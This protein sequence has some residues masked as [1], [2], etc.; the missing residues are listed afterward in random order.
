M[1]TTRLAT[2]SQRAREWKTLWGRLGWVG[3]DPTP[4][5][6]GE[7]GLP[8]L[9]MHPSSPWTGSGKQGARVT[10]FSCKFSN[11]HISTWWNVSNRFI[12]LFPPFQAAS[13]WGIFPSTCYLMNQ[14]TL[15]VGP[16]SII[17]LG[18]TQC[19]FSNSSILLHLWAVICPWLTTFIN[20]LTDVKY[21]LS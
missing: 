3:L 9:R 12:S 15:R 4:L 8:L 13:P 16:G 2:F 6:C 17:H 10:V 5:L 7:E 1:Q 20:Y 19:W 21:N 18:V 11:W 14:P